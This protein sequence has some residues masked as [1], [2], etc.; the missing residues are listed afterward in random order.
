V[1]HE[2]GLDIVELSGEKIA[3]NEIWFDLTAFM[4]AISQNPIL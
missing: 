3:R 4:K 1:I 2:T